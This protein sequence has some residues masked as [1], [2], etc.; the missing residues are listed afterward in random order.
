MSD[1]VMVIAQNVFRDE[2]YAEPKAVLERSGA[3]VTTASSAPGK[4]IGKLGMV[5]DA[6]ISVADA[7]NR[8]WDAAVFIGG[9]G[10][11]VFFDDPD[12][13]RLARG[14][15]E[16]GSIVGAICIAP[17]TLA[18]AGLLEGVARDCVRLA[19]RGSDRARRRL[20]RRSGHGRRT[21]RDR[22]RARGGAAVRRGARRAARRR[23]FA[24]LELPACEQRGGES[25]D[26]GTRDRGR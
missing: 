14:T 7:A 6:E 11:A 16:R 15:F 25:H 1:V 18:R 26:R 3:R 17:S 19:A 10:A 22:Q 4:C 13:H 2:E 5:A 23:E 20:D 24:A 21:H 9:A 8:A 12:A